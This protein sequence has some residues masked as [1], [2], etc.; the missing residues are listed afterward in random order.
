MY[1]LHTYYEARRPQEQN[2]LHVAD[3]GLSNKCVEWEAEDEV[4][5]V[6]LSTLNSIE[7]EKFDYWIQPLYVNCFILV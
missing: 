1:K 3:G 2:S 7:D 6:F 5:L 4:Y